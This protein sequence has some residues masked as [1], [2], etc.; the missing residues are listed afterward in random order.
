MPYTWSGEGGGVAGRKHTETTT[1]PIFS[2]L[3]LYVYLH[4]IK[5]KLKIHRHD[6][7]V[8]HMT[9]FFT[10]I[11]TGRYTLYEK[12][13]SY[14]SQIILLLTQYWVKG[15]KSIFSLTVSQMTKKEKKK[16]FSFLS[17]LTFGSTSFL[18]IKK[19]WRTVLSCAI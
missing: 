17:A 11:F 2:Q 7:N 15:K 6:S 16:L 12:S 13:T 1:S 14:A 3:F 8:C 9:I 18:Q 19:I 5:L 4:S 10:H